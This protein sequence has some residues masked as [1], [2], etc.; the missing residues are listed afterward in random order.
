MVVSEKKLSNIKIIIADD[1]PLIR[2]GIRTLLEREPDFNVV[3]E[4]CDGEEAV[5]LARK[6]KPDVVLMDVGMPILSGLEATRLIKAECPDISVLV[7][8]IHDD[9]R[10]IIGFL[11]AGASGYLLKSAYGEELVHS[12]RALRAGTLVIHTT[13]AEKLINGFDSHQLGKVKLDG[14]EQL[15]VREIE[16]LKLAARGMVNSD[17]ARELN[18]GVR[19]IKGYL[20]N[21]YA[22]L[23]VNSRTEAVVCAIQ[24][25]WIA[26]GEGTGKST[27]A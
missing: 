1:H 6:Y 4:A 9:E 25:G 18:V 2:Q 5:E 20:V 14:V 16:V 13:V 7:L 17:I 3:A 12:I 15:T 11:K 21:I 19:T 22:K 26:L 23:G 24:Q 27:D 10:Y 8:T